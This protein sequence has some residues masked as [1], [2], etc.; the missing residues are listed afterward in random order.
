MEEK[1]AVQAKTWLVLKRLFFFTKPHLLW[2]AIPIFAAILVAV[3]NIIF[4]IGI[5]GLIDASLASDFTKLWFYILLMIG[6]VTI[7]IP[8]NF[9]R[10][11]GAGRF[12]EYSL[13]IFV[14][15]P[16]IISIIYPFPISIHILREI[17]SH[18]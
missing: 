8:G 10:N 2:L 9:F 18:D 11:Y 1:D 12:A 5:K 17:W 13:F 14:R 15:K 7:E 6:A 16:P 3:V 4:A